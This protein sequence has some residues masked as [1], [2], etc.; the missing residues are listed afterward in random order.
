[1]FAGGRLACGFGTGWMAE[2][3]DAV[4]VPFAGRAARL[5]EIIE[6]VKAL[7]SG[8]MVEHHGDH[9]DFGAM[10]MRPRPH[11]DIPI[12]VGGH[13]DRTLQRAVRN[14]GWI[15]AHQSV[16][17][18]AHDVSR[19][20]RMVEDTDRAHPTF[21]VMATISSR[22]Q[23][24]DAEAL[25]AAGVDAVVIPAAVI[26]RAPAL[27]LRIEAIRSFANAQISRN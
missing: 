27:D 23:V 6:V 9:F 16:E 25:A 3:Y 15:A 5:D 26:E 20:R 11:G 8:E 12:Y 4:H 18:T 7:W 2:E 19:V 22:R 13:A 17:T 10:L 21:T 1:V 24:A 14:D